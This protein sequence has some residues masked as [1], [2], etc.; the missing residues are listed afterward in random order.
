VRF[1]CV[2]WAVEIVNDRGV[3]PTAGASRGRLETF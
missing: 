1:W 3:L 2:G